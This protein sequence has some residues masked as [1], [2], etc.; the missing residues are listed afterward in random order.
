MPPSAHSLLRLVVP[1]LALAMLFAAS[2]SD[3]RAQAAPDERMAI[4]LAQVDPLAG[5]L[6]DLFR[7][8]RDRRLRRVEPRQRQL[9]PRERQQQ[10][11][12][13]PAEPVVRIKPKD[14]DARVVAVFGDILAKGMAKGLDTA[15]AEDP[16]IAIR[17]ITR[18]GAGLVRDDYQDWP[19][20]IG[21]HLAKQ[22]TRVDVA[23]IFMGVNDRQPF[24]VDGQRIK[25]R[26]AEW[27]TLYR[28]RIDA[29]LELFAERGI[30]VIWLGLP[31]V[32]GP[33]T[34]QDL[35]F[36]NALYLDAVNAQNGIFVDIWNSFIGE[37]DRY[38]S[39][40]PDIRGQRR[41]LRTNNGIGFTRAGFRKLAFFVERQVRRLIGRGDLIALPGATP[42]DGGP[43][44]RKTGIG[45]IVD[46]T[47][48]IAARRGILAGAPKEKPPERDDE[49]A[50]QQVLIDGAAL[51]VVGG[52]PADKQQPDEQASEAGEDTKP[53]GAAGPQAALTR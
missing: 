7:P 49:S 23:V 26:T 34:R 5:F 22:G 44:P 16:S 9:R 21:E 39:F 35:L 24:R 12:Q 37:N 17:P 8:R 33:K 4:Q 6:R 52:V 46:L 29:V 36:F 13:R 28:Q 18:N 25:L 20:V 48:P 40:G 50:Y 32:T 42:Q 31:P 10:Q 53:D 1:V 47:G 43:D 3:V 2:P 30:P 14:P 38:T 27:E 11:R 15:F 45:R 51:P 19:V 41:R